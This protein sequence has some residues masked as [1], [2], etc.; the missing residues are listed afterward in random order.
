[1][2]SLFKKKQPAANVPEWAA[3]LTSKEYPLFINALDSYFTSKNIT[4]TIGDG[5][6]QVSEN[7]F[8]FQQLGLSNIVQV[9]KQHGPKHYKEMVFGHFDSMV[10]SHRF[11]KEFEQ[12][13]DDFNKVKQYVGVRLYDNQYI[14]HIGHKNVLGKAFAPGVYGMLIYDLPTSITNVQPDHLNKW[15]LSLDEVYNIG[16]EN[17]SQNNPVNLVNQAIGEINIMYG[18]TDHF[19]APNALF[20]I[21]KNNLLGSKGS[22]IGIPHRHAVISYP[23]ENMEAIQAVNSLIPIISGM[24]DEGP[25]SLSP[26]LFYYKNG[27][28][29]SI[30]YNIEEGKLQIM[31]PQEFVDLL[32]ELKEN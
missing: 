20:N 13:V 19:F 3:I 23:I 6:V 2:F 4:Y 24:Y 15:E 7:D 32:E 21:E 12:I 28:Y 22:L 27:S 9:C 11:S 16:I 10:E 25:G 30:P 14:E 1:M 26:N 31:P 29:T 5:V 17:I 8:G 18:A